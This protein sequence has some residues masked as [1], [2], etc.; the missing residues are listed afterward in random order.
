MR[1]I[2][3]HQPHLV[4]RACGAKWCR[5]RRLYRTRCN[6]PIS[7]GP[8]SSVAVRPC[9][10]SV[11]ISEIV[12][13]LVAVSVM[14]IRPRTRLAEDVTVIHARPWRQFALPEH[15][16]LIAGIQS[17]AGRRRDQIALAAQGDVSHEW[18]TWLQPSALVHIHLQH[19]EWASRQS[20]PQAQPT[21]RAAG[22]RAAASHRPERYRRIRHEQHT[23][24]AM[25]L[26]P[27][28]TA[29]TSRPAGSGSDCG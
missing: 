14:G 15:M 27:P 7:T 26:V 29:R 6:R 21:G 1:N 5:G 20:A 25:Y 24:S 23:P 22:R 11:R 18:R 19:L 17:H 28:T 8:I 13:A 12:A 2:R 10:E 3:C 16:R 4:R 9:T